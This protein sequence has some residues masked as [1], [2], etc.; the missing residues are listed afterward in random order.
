MSPA[1]KESREDIRRRVIATS[2]RNRRRQITVGIAVAIAVMALV[3]WV[4]VRALPSVASAPLT[5]E[6]LPKGVDPV[7]YGVRIGTG[8]VVIDE[9]FDFLCPVCRRV[10]QETS[11]ELDGLVREGKATVVY[12]PVALLDDYTSPGGYS[13]RAASAGG[14]AA[15]AGVFPR[16]YGLLMNRQPEE[17]G[18]G[19]SDQQ[20]I[21]FAIESGARPEEVADCIAEGR[22]RPWVEA[23][24]DRA[25]GVARIVATPT[26]LVEGTPISIAEGLVVPALKAA[27]SQADHP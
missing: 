10:E 2:A 21:E 20:L 1:E 5:S 12:H 9:Y 26:I 23:A 18:P 8:P 16:F 14:C 3:G 15:E 7:T 19:L 22:F 11:L 6:Q 4:V 27:V 13:T 25:G 24:T 17:G